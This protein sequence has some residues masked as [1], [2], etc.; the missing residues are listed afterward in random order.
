[1]SNK[2]AFYFR[3]GSQ[4]QLETTYKKEI[5]KLKSFAVLNDLEIVKIFSEVRSGL[6]STS[7]VEQVL[8]FM[9]SEGIDDLIVPDW[10]TVS[11]RPYDLHKLCE[12][13]ADNNKHIV[14][15]ND[16]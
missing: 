9:I 1:M 16:Y 2:V 7:S 5:D 3:V 13:F 6:S 4:E 10:K 8:D 15:M 14:T 11:R 12:K